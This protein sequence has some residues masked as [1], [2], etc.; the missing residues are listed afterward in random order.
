MTKGSPI[1]RKAIELMKLLRAGWMSEREAS[2]EL[3][4]SRHTMRA[5]LR[6]WVA[7]GLLVARIRVVGDSHRGPAP[8][9]Y[10]LAKEWGGQAR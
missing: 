6:D 10:A 3:L 1:C 9:E 8:I 5:W 7:S 4:W 2:T